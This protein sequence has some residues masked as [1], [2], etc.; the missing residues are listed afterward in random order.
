MEADAVIAYILSKVLPLAILPLGLGLVLLLLGLSTRRRWP[1]IMASLLLWV[2]SLEVISQ[3]LWRFLE[4]PWQR[5]LVDSVLTADAIVVLSGGRHPAP[6]KARISEWHD[7]DRFLAGLELFRAGK[8]SRLLFTG[9]TSPF[10]PGQQPE[11][12]VY[13][14]STT[15]RIKRSDG[16]YATCANTAQAVVYASG[17]SV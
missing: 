12:Q 6:G 11:G 15:A 3:T 17:S 10:R 1:V 7:S 2:F 14:R 4:A 13:A 5:Q 16:Q 8:A 9:G